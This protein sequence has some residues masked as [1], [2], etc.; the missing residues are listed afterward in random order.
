MQTHA[1]GEQWSQGCLWYPR[2]RYA[3]DGHNAHF[4][5][6]DLDWFKRRIGPSLPNCNNM[7]VYPECGRLGQSVE[8]G[9]KRRIFAIG[10]FINQRLLRPIHDWLMAVLRR[11]PCD[12]T[13][14]QTRP[15][16]NLVGEQTCYSF[17]L[18]STTDRWPLYFLFEIFQVG[19][20]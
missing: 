1:Q 10:N 9:G 8:G 2:I 17:D 13:F 6:H 16:D 12:G 3:F 19:G 14:H 5:A 18:K 7:G 11:L 15:L 4:T 20:V